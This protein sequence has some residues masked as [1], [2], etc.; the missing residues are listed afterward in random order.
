MNI[1][2]SYKQTGVSKEELDLTLWLI[3]SHIEQLWHNCFIYY[4]DIDFSNQEASEIISNAKD[5]IKESDIVISFINYSWR[6]EWMM[7]ELWIAYALDKKIILLVNNNVKDE[8]FLTYWLS[9]NTYFFD[10]K[11]DIIKSLWEIIK[12]D[13]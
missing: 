9:T 11:I 13:T 3:K 8:Y 2:I 7:Q 1:F 6:S 10:N 4:F 12:K 5:K